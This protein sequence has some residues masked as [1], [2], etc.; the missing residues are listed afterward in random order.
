MTMLHF[1]WSYL[2]VNWQIKTKFLF[3]DLKFLFHDQTALFIVRRGCHKRRPQ[4]GG[5]EFVQR[6]RFATRGFFRC[7]RPHFLAHLTSDFSKFMVYTHGQGGWA[8]ANKGGGGLIFFRFCTDVFYWRRLKLW[9]NL[10]NLYFLQSLKIVVIMHQIHSRLQ[11][12][13]RAS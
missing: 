9:F 13:Y 11:R 8:S 1:H 3:H 2:Q 6:R 5:R 7:G 12:R 10:Q 4:S